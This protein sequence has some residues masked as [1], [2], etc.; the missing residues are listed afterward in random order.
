MSVDET[1]PLRVL[2]VGGDASA[3]ADVARLLSA[4]DELNVV[5]EAE[6]AA[7]AVELAGRLRP[8]IVLLDASAARAGRTAELARAARV[9]VLAGPDDPATVDSAVRGGACG[10]LVPGA[11]TARDVLRGVRDASRVSMGLSAREAEVMDLIATGRSNG[12]IARQLFL[13]EKTVKNHVNRIYAKLGVS[14]RATAIAFWRGM[15]SVLPGRD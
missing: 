11:F 7:A 15:V 6:Q 10:H 1:A 5:A 13:S 9:F 4:S 14:S 8:D 3:R 2:V 12:E